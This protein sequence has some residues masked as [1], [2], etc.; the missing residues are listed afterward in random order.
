MR[1]PGRLREL[2]RPIG[3]EPI[4]DPPSDAE[5]I[6]RSLVDPSDFA[7]IFDRHAPTLLGYCTRRLGRVDAEDVLAEAFR[8]AF[9]TRD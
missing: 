4:V 1:L 6:R 9:E 2:R 8:I 5:M 7:G 3:K